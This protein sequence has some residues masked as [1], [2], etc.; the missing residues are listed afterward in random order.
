MQ[1]FIFCEQCEDVGTRLVAVNDHVD[2]GRDDW[3]LHAFFATMRHEMYNADTAKR[4]RRSLRN[5]FQQGGVVQT[6]VY[7]YVKPPGAKTDADLRKD[8]DAE[9]VFAELFRQLEDGASYSEVADW[10]NAQGIR[11]GPAVRAARWNCSLVTQLIHN[12]ILKGLRVRN[13]KMSK[14]VNQTG[15]RK[16]VA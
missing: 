16:S 11:P 5:R 2:T 15:R 12:P 6:V 1:A 9:P 10:L 8:P 13:K 14:R 7:G 3:R 4:I